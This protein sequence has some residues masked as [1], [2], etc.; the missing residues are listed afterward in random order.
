MGAEGGGREG[1][2]AENYTDAPENVE[3]EAD[4]LAASS[5]INFLRGFSDR[6]ALIREV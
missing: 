5:V 6:A 4:W 1:R 2:G 3:G